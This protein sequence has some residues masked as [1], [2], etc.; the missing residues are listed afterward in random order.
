[1][2][3]KM[4]THMHM[5]IYTWWCWHISEGGGVWAVQAFSRSGNDQFPLHRKLEEVAKSRNKFTLRNTRQ[6]WRTA[7]TDAGQGV[8]RLTLDALCW[9]GATDAGTFMRQTHDISICRCCV[10]GIS[11]SRCNRRWRASVAAP[12]ILDPYWRASDARWTLRTQSVR[13]IWWFILDRWIS[14]E[15][16]HVASLGVT[17][18]MDRVCRSSDGRVC[19]AR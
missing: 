10:V 18:A 14:S 3:V 2:I 11:A 13:R 9:S 7:A 15:D 19:R 16:G 4:L 5:V 1:M 8:Y 17:D 12:S 6:T